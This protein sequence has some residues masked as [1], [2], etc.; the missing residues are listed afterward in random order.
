MKFA[1]DAV[2]AGEILA[3]TVKSGDVILIKGSR[4]VKLE[5]AMDTLREKNM[6]E[7]LWESGKAPW[8]VW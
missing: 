8:K 4:G 3:Q 7:H 6:L 1:A 5:Q 2:H